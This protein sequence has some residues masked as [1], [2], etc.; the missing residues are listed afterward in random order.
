MR[1]Y[2]NCRNQIACEKHQVN[3]LEVEF[4]YG[5]SN[6]CYVIVS[7]GEDSNSHGNAYVF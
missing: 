2:G 1:W 7:S 6:V 4:L 3:L 5:Q